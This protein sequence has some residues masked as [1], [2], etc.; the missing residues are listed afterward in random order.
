M[1]GEGGLAWLPTSQSQATAATHFLSC[2]SIPWDIQGL[3]LKTQLFSELDTT[4]VSFSAVLR[5]LW[6]YELYV[7][8]R[9]RYRNP[10]CSEMFNLGTPVLF[11]T[12]HHKMYTCST[13]WRPWRGDTVQCTCL[14][15]CW[16]SVIVAQVVNVSTC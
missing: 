11:K 15:A 12:G 5:G 9:G 7:R 8:T 1:G 2:R 14:P 10:S 13:C 6:S 3:L 4:R 16:R